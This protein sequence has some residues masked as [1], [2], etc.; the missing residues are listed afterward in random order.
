[1]A[2]I[3]DS[4]E[5]S[6]R[7][8]LGFYGLVSFLIFLLYTF[9]VALGFFML[10]STVQFGFFESGS[11]SEWNLTGFFEWLLSFEWFSK[12]LTD[13]LFLLVILYIYT[14]ITWIYVYYSTVKIVFCGEK[15]KDWSLGW[16]LGGW[17]AFI[18][19]FFVPAI[20]AVQNLPFRAKN[21][22]YKFH[23]NIRL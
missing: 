17:L 22:H 8:S 16:Y 7:N 2:E 9:I 15:E 5:K 12:F 4:E 13:S 18:S 10:F 1:M 20:L 14:I 23:L 3:I 11:F 19:I 6:I 21:V